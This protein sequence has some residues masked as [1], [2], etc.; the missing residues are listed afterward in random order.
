M[1]FFQPTN[2]RI[3]TRVKT[4]ASVVE[5]VIAWH[6]LARLDL[7]AHT[8]SKTNVPVLATIPASKVLIALIVD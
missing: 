4:V 7:L 3:G 8:V 2:A 5:K 6:A 1:I